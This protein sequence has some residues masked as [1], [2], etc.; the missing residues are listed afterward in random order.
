MGWTHMRHFPH[1]IRGLVLAGHM[2]RPPPTR[3]QAHL[4]FSE[5]WW[6]LCKCRGGEEW[7]RLILASPHPFPH[8]TLHWPWPPFQWVGG[9][10]CKV[11]GMGLSQNGTHPAHH[12][13]ARSMS[14][15]D[16][17]SK[18]RLFAVRHMHRP[19]CFFRVLVAPVQMQ[20]GR[21]MGEAPSGIPTSFP[22]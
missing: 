10:T 7:G 1:V 16:A 15:A 11:V 19:P 22:S 18:L 6:H 2:H 5:C 12:H 13:S 9:E 3:R 14:C 20:R 4:F 17:A 8:E 21:R